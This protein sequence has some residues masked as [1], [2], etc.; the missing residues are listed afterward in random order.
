[1]WQ[2]IKSHFRKWFRRETSTPA[3]EANR[4]ARRAAQIVTRRSARLVYQRRNGI[5]PLMETIKT[6]QRTR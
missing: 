2:W 1:M 6:R 5:E 3:P 4:Q